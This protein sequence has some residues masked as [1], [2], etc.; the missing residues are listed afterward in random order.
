MPESDRVT[1]GMR[2]KR[3]WK[4]REL[5][6]RQGKRKNTDDFDNDDDDDNDLLRQ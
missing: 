6:R 1:L 3:E 5:E 2:Q 4:L